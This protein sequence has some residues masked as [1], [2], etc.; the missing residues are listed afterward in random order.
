M[1]D[2]PS[3]AFLTGSP[4]GGTPKKKRSMYAS[5]FDK[6][7]PGGSDYSDE[8]KDKLARQGLLNLGL[9]MLQT[10]GGFGNALGAGV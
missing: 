3:A 6:F 2:Y 7:V 4:I 9:T 1:M 5:V 10:G 8:D